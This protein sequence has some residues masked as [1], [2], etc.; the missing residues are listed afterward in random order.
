MRL[1]LSLFFCLQLF[2]SLGQQYPYR[3]TISKLCSPEFAGRGYVDEGSTKAANLIAA[4]FQ[5]MGLQPFKKKFLQ[6]FTLPVQTFPGACTFVLGN[7]TLQPG[8]DYLVE[9]SCPA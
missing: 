6:P 5:K 4:A 2:S 9:P 8:V 1:A 3:E 7:D